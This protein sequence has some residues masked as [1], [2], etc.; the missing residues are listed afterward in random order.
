MERG[1]AYAARKLTPCCPKCLTELEQPEHWTA[2]TPEQK[3]ATFTLW[4]GLCKLVVS[5]RFYVGAGE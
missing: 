5:G 3:T 4:C 1:F 2:M